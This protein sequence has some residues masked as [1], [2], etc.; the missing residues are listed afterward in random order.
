[1]AIYRQFK[2]YWPEWP[3]WE[4]DNPYCSTGCTPVATMIA[5]SYW[6]QRYTYLIEGNIDPATS[7][8]NDSVVVAATKTVRFELQ[9]HCTENGQGSTSLAPLAGRLETAIDALAEQEVGWNAETHECDNDPQLRRHH[10][11]EAVD[12]GHPPLVHYFV[13][14][15]QNEVCAA[16]EAINHSGVVYG[17][18]D[19]PSG[20]GRADQIKIA[21]GWGTSARIQIV[22]VDA[23]GAMHITDL[24]PGCHSADDGNICMEFSDITPDIEWGRPATETLSCMCVMRGEPDG[25]FRPYDNISKAEFLKIVLKL[26][27][28]PEQ[29]DKDGVR[30]EEI[31]HGVCPGHWASGY[32]EFADGEGLLDGLLTGG[33]FAADDPITRQEAAWLLVQAGA[34]HDDGTPPAQGSSFWT[35]YKMYDNY[36]CYKNKVTINDNPYTDFDAEDYLPVYDHILATTNQ[37]V[38][39]GVKVDP[40][41]PNTDRHF[42]PNDPITRIGAA[43]VACAARFGGGSSKCSSNFDCLDVADFGCD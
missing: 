18:I 16:P 8:H 35:F 32:I 39:E 12:R 5:L 28:S 40:D 14:Q 42:L 19:Y 33:S 27:Y 37:C 34:H 10:V 20:D 23:Q 26:A 29:V 4:G 3:N 36:Q 13:Y 9:T 6:D 24:S 22:D 17:Y 1:M 15:D 25:R 7:K 11:W 2:N 30:A 38:F 21:K 31:V 41:D 43:K